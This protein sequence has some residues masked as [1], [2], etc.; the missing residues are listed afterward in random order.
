VR[1]STAEANGW[2]CPQ[3]G[4]A[5]TCDHSGRGYVNHRK[6]R[7][8]PLERG[9]WDGIEAAASAGPT[10]SFRHGQGTGEFGQWL[11]RHLQSEDAFSDHLLFYDH[12]NKRLD[13]N[14]RAVKAFVGE[15]VAN[16]NR[17]AD[18]DV[19]VI[20]PDGTV[21]VLIEIGLPLGRGR[22]S[23]TSMST[24][25]RSSSSWARWH[26]LGERSR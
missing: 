21:A 24:M 3:C 23:A 14:V 1:T 11:G 8:C 9:E 13:P 12:G 19:I 25:R 4:D 26:R 15:R 17:I 6:N 22:A 10:T 20:K 5:T 7:D 18:V 2:R 16:D